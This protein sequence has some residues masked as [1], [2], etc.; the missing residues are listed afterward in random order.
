M[1]SL[2]KKLIV[3]LVAAGA[4]A[5]L[6]FAFIEGRKE[7]SAEAEREKPVKAPTRVEVVNGENIVTFD[8]ATRTGSGVALGQLEAI[9]HRPEIRAYGTVL[10]LGELTDLRNGIA[11]AAAQLAKANAAVEVARKDYERVKGLFQTNQNVSEKVVQV[12][13]GTLRTEEANAQAAHAALDATHA[14]ARQHWGAVVSTWLAEG[15]PEFERLRLQNDLLIQVTFA[16]SSSAMGAPAEATV[17][18]ASGRLVAAKF[19]SPALRTD[20]KIQG[21]SFFYVVSADDSDLLPGMNVTALLPA[22]EAA[23]GFVVPTSAVVWLQGKSWAYAQ[24]KPDKFAR[25]E[26]STEQPVNGG[27]FQAK[28]FAADEVIVSKGPQVLLSE[29]FRAQISVGEEGK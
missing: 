22:G 12:A 25:R 20:P 27:W 15:A 6:V 2:G 24:V 5:G 23:S 14:T 18:T 16:P 1:K 11:T 26:V 17:Q 7:A 19:V 4:L 3:I 13:E 9:S 21:R 29:E 28:A 10:D 8:A